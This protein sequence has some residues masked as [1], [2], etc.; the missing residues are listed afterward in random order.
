MSSS[1][2]SVINNPDGSTT[3]RTD[4]EPVYAPGAGL[5]IGGAIGGLF[6]LPYVIVGTL[7]VSVY[8]IFKK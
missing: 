7:A 8:Y 4:Y 5:V 2:T 3:T 1:V 6:L